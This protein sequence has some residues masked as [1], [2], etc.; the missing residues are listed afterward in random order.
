MFDTSRMA[1]SSEKYRYARIVVGR[2]AIM[3]D[4]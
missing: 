3:A 1:S 2:P 4:S